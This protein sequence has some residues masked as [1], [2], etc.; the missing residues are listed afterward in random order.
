MYYSNK[1]A[2]S[3]NKPKTTWSI[4]KSITNN[5]K[6]CKNIP[7]IQI[8]GKTT[9]HYQTIVEKFNNYYISVA[10]NITNG[11]F[12]KNIIDDLIKINPFN[13]LYSAFKQ[14]FTNIALKNV[15]TYET[16]KIIKELKNKNSCG[17]DEVKVKILKISSHFIISPL[18]YICN[19]MLT[20]GTFP[21]RLK[22]SE[23]IP[24]Y[25]KGDRTLI[26]NYKPISLLPVF[27]LKFLKK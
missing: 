5:K 6:N 1:L 12:P 25:E 17:Y 2:N 22:F 24:I 19:R 9:T 13:Y 14:P 16:E 27:F 23:I 3:D 7:M 20:I 18:T 8:D 21:D 26:Y 15:T 11:N 10:D 4:I